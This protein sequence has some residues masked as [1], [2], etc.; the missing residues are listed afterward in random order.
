MSERKELNL[1]LTEFAEKAFEFNGCIGLMFW[2]NIPKIQATV[3][4]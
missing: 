4:L 2:R 3:I 1:S